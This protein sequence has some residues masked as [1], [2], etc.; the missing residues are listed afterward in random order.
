MMPFAFDLISTLVIGSTL[1]V[2]TTDLHHRAAL[3]GGELRRVDV[4]GGAV[5]RREP[6]TAATDERAR[7]PE[8]MYRRF[9]DFWLQSHNGLL[10]SRDARSSSGQ[11]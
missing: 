6:G 3:D 11:R 7:R 5:E 2:A 10:R 4:G 1:P 8:P 9:R